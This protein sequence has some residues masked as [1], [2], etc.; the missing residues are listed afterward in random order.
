[1][2]KNFFIKKV[3]CGKKE[4]VGTQSEFEHCKPQW[5]KQ[6]DCGLLSFAVCYYAKIRG[7]LIFVRKRSEKGERSE[8]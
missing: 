1:M 2:Y 7:R 5:A 8:G 6:S 3:V 4:G